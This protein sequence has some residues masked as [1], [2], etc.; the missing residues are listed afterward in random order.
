MS[1]AYTPPPPQPPHGDG[2]FYDADNINTVGRFPY[3]D[4]RYTGLANRAVE[5]ARN[6]VNLRPSGAL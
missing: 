1:S 6:A 3:T 4:G 2:L 5:T